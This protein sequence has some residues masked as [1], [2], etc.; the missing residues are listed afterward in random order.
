MP[1]SMPR[2]RRREDNRTA[3]GL[4]QPHIVVA[5]GKAAATIKTVVAR[6]DRAIQY[7]AASRF[8]ISVS[9]ILGRPVKPGDDNRGRGASEFNHFRRH[10]FAFSRRDPP[11]VCS[12]SLAP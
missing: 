5:R 1:G 10:G 12:K 6:L 9:G 3:H 11:E 8:I 4:T 7:A 2:R